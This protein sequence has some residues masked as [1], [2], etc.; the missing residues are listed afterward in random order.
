MARVRISAVP[1]AQ[2]KV[3]SDS[4]F[5]T[6][7]EHFFKFLGKACSIVSVWGAIYYSN[8]ILIYCYYRFLDLYVSLSTGANAMDRSPYYILCGAHLQH[9]FYGYALRHRTH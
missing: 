1:R 9:K 7:H 4:R 2:I 6:I 3:R 8:Q 5:D